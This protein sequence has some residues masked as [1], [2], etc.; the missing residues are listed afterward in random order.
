MET[1]RSVVRRRTRPPRMF[2]SQFNTAARW[3]ISDRTMQRLVA[4]PPPGFPRPVRI[5]RRNHFAIAEVE[6]YEAR[7]VGEARA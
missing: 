7:Q 2:I 6:A 4:D 1:D 3:G 5:G